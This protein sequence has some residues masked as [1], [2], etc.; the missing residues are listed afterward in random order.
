VS[1]PNVGGQDND[2]AGD[3]LAFIA[4][5]GAPLGTKPIGDRGIDMSRTGEV[6][7]ADVPAVALNTVDD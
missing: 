4:A 2:T 6:G 7:S 3:P 1:G 5:H